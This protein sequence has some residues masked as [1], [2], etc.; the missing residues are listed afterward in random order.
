MIGNQIK[1]FRSE[2]GMTQQNLADKL[3]VTAQAVSR[4]ENGE[5]EPSLGT[6]TE[7]AKIFGVTTDEM[8]GIAAPSPQAAPAPEPEVIIKKEKEYVYKDPPP[9]VLAVCEKCNRP[10]YKGNEIVRQSFG[11]GRTRQTIRTICVQCDRKEKAAHLKMMRATAAHRRRLSYILGGLGAALVLGVMIWFGAFQTPSTIAP[12]IIAPISAFT[13]ISCLL[14]R[15]NFIMDMMGGIAGFSI[16]MP[17]LIFELDLDGIL[18]LLTVKLALWIL[19]FLLSAAC[20][21]LALLLGLALSLFVYPYAIVKNIK[22]PED[23]DFD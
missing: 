14:F 9:P 2:Q 4:W 7:M 3:F 10:I 16:R 12:G 13:L 6:I 22:H 5:V 15:N 18:W 23:S 21:L 17:G 19:G 11:G 8:L 20:F 1:K